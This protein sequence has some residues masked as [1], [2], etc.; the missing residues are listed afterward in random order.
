MSNNSI[1]PEI[2]KLVTY[3]DTTFIEGFKAV[4]EPWHMFAAA[5]VLTNPWAGQVVD[6]LRPC[7]QAIAPVIGEMLSARV[8][9]MAGGGDKIEAY[10]KAAIVGM[11][12]EIEHASG[13]THTLRFGN[14]YREAV[15]AKSY[16]SFTNLRGPANTA[17]T[18]PMMDKIDA[19]RRSHYLTLQFSIGDAPG[20]D[21][22][23]VALGGATTGRPHHRIGDRYQDLAEMGNDV[24]N[25]AGV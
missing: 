5:A 8:V 13:L 19:G 22:I 4:A 12:G 15:G 9:E 11:N 21:E 17:I 23:L 16:L 2:R 1:T 24:D 18:I 20:P 3:E 14:F 10:G 7:I 25:P 6:N